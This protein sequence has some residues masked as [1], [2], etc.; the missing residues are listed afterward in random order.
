MFS[1]LTL[2]KMKFHKDH[3]KKRSRVKELNLV[4]RIRSTEK[5]TYLTAHVGGEDIPLGALGAGANTVYMIREAAPGTQGTFRLYCSC[6][7]Q[8]H[9]R[10]WGNA[11]KHIE[12]L[13]LEY[14]EFKARDS[15]FTNEV[16]IYDPAAVER[17]VEATI[18]RAAWLADL[19]TQDPFAGISD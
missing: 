14:P 1:P 19:E 2:A 9:N 7:D 15:M 5:G 11:C 12:K 16:I 3:W 18:A 10:G 4:A 13:M 6:P 17:A 8:L